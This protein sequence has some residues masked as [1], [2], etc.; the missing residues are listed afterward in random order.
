[1]DLLQIAIVHEQRP[2]AHEPAGAVNKQLKCYGSLA[3]RGDRHLI[4][5]LQTEAAVDSSA[6]A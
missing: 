3:V 1:M 5:V 2:A 6:F 4:V